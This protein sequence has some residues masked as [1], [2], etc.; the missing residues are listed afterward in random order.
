MAYYNLK[1]VEFDKQLH[2]KCFGRCVN[3][4]DVFLS[5]DKKLKKMSDSVKPVR[6]SR[7]SEYFVKSAHMHSVNVSKHRTIDSIYSYALSNHWEGFVTLTF[8]PQIVDS[9][10]YEVCSLKVKNWLGNLRRRYC[11]DLKYII[12][13]ELHA[14]KV[15]FHFHALFSSFQRMPLV[16]SGHVDNNGRIIYNLP[17][18]GYGFSTMTLINS[19][20][21]ERAV[22]YIVKYISK[23]LCAALFGKKRF[24][25]SNNLV[26]PL[27]REYTV[28]DFENLITTCSN[29][30][31][32]NRV[33][34]SSVPA[35]GQDV[36][37][38]YLDKDGK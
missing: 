20:S 28:E 8:D 6:I 26:K 19:D 3:K 27:N 1:V 2:V 16:D 24:W 21:S 37:Y 30:G 36:I 32:I 5:A 15:K 12:V 7:Y 10:D 11:P 35:A 13:P 31:I 22:S 23:D 33:S 25:H 34:S 14:D 9:S 4:T 17:L 29:S 18:W 38:L